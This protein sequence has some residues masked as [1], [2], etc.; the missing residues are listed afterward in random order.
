[1]ECERVVLSA[2]AL[3]FS[4]QEFSQSLGL[5]VSVILVVLFMLAC[6]STWI[7][8]A[9]SSSPHV[10]L[11]GCDSSFSNKMVAIPFSLAGWTISRFSCSKI[12]LGA[13]IVEPNGTILS[14][15]SLSLF[16][17][18]VAPRADLSKRTDVMISL[19]AWQDLIFCSSSPSSLYVSIS[20]LLSSISAL[21]LRL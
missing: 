7:D 5:L 13:D 11:R 3:L 20:Q 10:T 4:S 1:M 19:Q 21:G 15:A 12:A 14:R 9:P 8:A 18:S 6:I 17:V 2:N 16:H